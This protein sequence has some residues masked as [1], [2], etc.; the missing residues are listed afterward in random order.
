[1]RARCPFSS[2][3]SMASP[4]ERVLRV[5]LRVHDD[6]GDD[7]ERRRPS[8]TRRRCSERGSR[9]GSCSGARSRTGSGGIGIVLV[10]VVLFPTGGRSLFRSEVPGHQP[11]GRPAKSARQRARSSSRLRRADGDSGRRHVAPRARRCL[12]GVGFTRSAPWPRGASRTI[13][14]ASLFYSIP[15]RSSWCILDL[16]VHERGSTSAFYDTFLRKGWAGAWNAAKNSS[17]IRT[18]AGLVLGCALFIGFVLWFWGGEQWRRD[19][20]APELLVP[21]A[22]PA[23][24]PVRGREPRHEYG[25]RNRELRRV[26]DGLPG[27]PD[28]AL[29][30]RRLRG[31]DRGGMKVV[32]LLVLAKAAM[33]GVRRFARPRRSIRC[34]WTAARWTTRWSA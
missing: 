3:A 29:H 34:A 9:A 11:R 6:R 21:D 2:P 32:R 10:F 12:R 31:L 16:H 17:E 7:H 1:M 26:A 14:P 15:G 19:V 8:T 23:R 27:P 4:V 33:Q 24:Q 30:Q 13:R 28:A 20:R 5:G 22:V 25:L 18:Y